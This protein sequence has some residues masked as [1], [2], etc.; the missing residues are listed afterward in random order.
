MI[1]TQFSVRDELVAAVG[2]AV[3]TLPADLEPL[4]EDRSGRLSDGAPLALVRARSIE[5]VQ[6][7]MR[8]A[9]LHRIPVV[10]RGAG[11]GLAGAATAGPGEIVLSTLAMNE[12]LE[13]NVDDELAG[14]PERRSQRGARPARAV[15]CPRPGQ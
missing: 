5:D 14:H 1:E 12:I 13:I 15:V 4:R 10:P 2:N 7:T 11:T 8:I 9:T 6:A 3:S